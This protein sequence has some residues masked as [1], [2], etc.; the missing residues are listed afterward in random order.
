[1]GANLLLAARKFCC[2]FSTGRPCYT[3]T[4]MCNI[5]NM[6]STRCVE[7]CQ[8]SDKLPDEMHGQPSCPQCAAYQTCCTSSCM[9]GCCHLRFLHQQTTGLGSVVHQRSVEATHHVVRHF[10]ATVTLPAARS[11]ADFV[12]SIAEHAIRVVCR[13]L[14]CCFVFRD[15]SAAGILSWTRLQ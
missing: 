10:E 9:T 13:G 12:Y 3:Y 6:I 4:G 15:S 7:N 1:M 8:F 14:H 11:L 5:L 2:A